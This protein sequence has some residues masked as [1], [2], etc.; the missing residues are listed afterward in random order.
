MKI[1]LIAAAAI[2]AV[3][4]ASAPPQKASQASSPADAASE[5]P[6]AG[7]SKDQP[8]K[9]KPVEDSLPAGQEAENAPPKP[10]D[11]PLGLPPEPQAKP[12]PRLSQSSPRNRPRRRVS[13]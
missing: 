13:R 8:A 7:P 12:E 9:D 6:S 2:M 11:V 5:R 4:C 1:L 3:S 10:A